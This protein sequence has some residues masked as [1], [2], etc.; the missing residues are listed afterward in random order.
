MRPRASTWGEE[1]RRCRAPGR[2]PAPAGPAVFVDRGTGAGRYSRNDMWL[3]SSRSTRSSA[4]VSIGPS[5]V[6]V[7]ANAS[8]APSRCG[9]QPA[10]A[11]PWGARAC[12]VRR[13]PA[14]AVR[15]GRRRAGSAPG[16]ATPALGQRPRREVG[17]SGEVALG[18]ARVL[19]R[20]REV[21]ALRG[22]DRPA[23]R[24]SARRVRRLGRQVR[25]CAACMVRRVVPVVGVGGEQ[26]QLRVRERRHRRKPPRGHAGRVLEPLPRRRG[27]CSA[28]WA[29]GPEQQGERL[30]GLSDG[31]SSPAR[32]ASA[33]IVARPSRAVQ[34]RRRTIAA[35]PSVRSARAAASVAR[36]AAA[37]WPAISWSTAAVSASR[38]SA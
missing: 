5:P 12:A 38:G 6:A 17:L 20:L 26:R 14:T 37:P 35:C 25:V 31:S 18:V 32:S 4:L 24:A 11:R 15:R 19:P 13:A 22:H 9:V 30:P 7:S 36:A 29:H 34:A 33:A 23:A 2:P 21:P 1:A 28:R 27:R 8:A 3:G 10:S 16:P